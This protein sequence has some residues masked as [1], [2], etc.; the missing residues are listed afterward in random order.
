ML[1]ARGQEIDKVLGLKLGADDYITKPFGFMELLARARG[2]AAPLCAAPSPSPSP[3]RPI[4]SATWTSTSGV[5]RRARRVRRSSCRRASSSFSP[6]SSSTA[7]RSSPAR[8]CST[9]CGITT[10]FLHA[11]GGHAHREA[12][13]EGRGQPGGSEARHHRAPPRLQVHRLS[14]PLPAPS[15]RHLSQTPLLAGVVTGLRNPRWLFSARFRTLRKEKV[16]LEIPQLRR[17][18]RGLLAHN[19]LRNRH[20]FPAGAVANS[21]F[22]PALGKEGLRCFTPRFDAS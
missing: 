1:T 21:G 18:K 3:W 10:P 16:F 12:A 22:R 13:Q 11:H 15:P 2:R 8:P 6:T 14:R 19:T 5:T 7:A 20:S 4:A 9:R 17:M